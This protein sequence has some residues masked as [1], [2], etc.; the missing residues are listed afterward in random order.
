MHGEMTQLN[1]CNRLFE[2]GGILRGM[3]SHEVVVRADAL[4][5][6]SLRVYDFGGRESIMYLE[7]EAVQRLR[8]L[9]SAT[10]DE[11]VGEDLE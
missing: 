10:M 5:R 1:L 3:I 7:L 8:V 2:T 11:T 4:A 6:G 9:C